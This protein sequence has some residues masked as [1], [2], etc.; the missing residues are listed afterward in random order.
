MCKGVCWHDVFDVCDHFPR[1]SEQSFGVQSVRPNCS[2][3]CGM[4]SVNA[5][6]DEP[7]MDVRVLALLRSTMLL[8]TLREGAV[9]GHDAVRHSRVPWVF[10]EVR[11][12]Q[13]ECHRDRFGVFS[14]AKADASNPA[15][16]ASRYVVATWLADKLVEGRTDQGTVAWACRLDSRPGGHALT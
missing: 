12:L 10:T 16:R 5:A 4:T 2:S 8:R 6:S 14:Q 15:K 7:G 3:T 11:R 13:R 1:A 9:L